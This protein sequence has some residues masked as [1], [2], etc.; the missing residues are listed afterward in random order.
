[1]HRGSVYVGTDDGSRLSSERNGRGN[2]GAAASV[3]SA[4]A[5]GGRYGSSSATPHV[6]WSGSRA[7]DGGSPSDPRSNLEL[8]ER[9]ELTRGAFDINDAAR[10]ID[11][12][13]R[14][15]GAPAWPESSTSRAAD[16]CIA[17]SRSGSASDDDDRRRARS[18]AIPRT[19]GSQGSTGRQ[20]SDD[21]RCHCGDH[22]MPPPPRPTD[23]HGAVARS[24]AER[25]RTRST[26]D[27]TN[28]RMFASS[29]FPPSTGHPIRAEKRAQHAARLNHCAGLM[30]GS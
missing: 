9:R 27:P 3:A 7:A 18:T 30:P 13:W 26:R 8:V 19:L 12:G 25:R 11:P 15:S 5:V 21:D 23:G 28:R 10:R 6:G 24:R 14:I 20:S 4:L 17:P 2:R 22:R 1:M 29:F 16:R